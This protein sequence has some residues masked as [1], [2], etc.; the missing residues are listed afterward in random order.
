MFRKKIK[1]STA[2]ANSSL[3]CIPMPYQEQAFS[4]L[5]QQVINL[6]QSIKEKLIQEYA[7]I[8]TKYQQHLEKL[9]CQLYAL[10]LSE[11][12][13]L[14]DMIMFVEGVKDIID[15]GHSLEDWC[16]EAD[17][18]Y[19]AIQNLLGKEK[20]FNNNLLAMLYHTTQVELLFKYDSLLD[21]D[22]Q[23]LS[24]SLSDGNL[25]HHEEERISCRQRLTMLLESGNCTDFNVTSTR[26]QALINGHITALRSL[27][28]EY[29]DIK[30]WLFDLFDLID[31]ENQDFIARS[32]GRSHTFESDIKKFI[33]HCKKIYIDVN[34]E[35]IARNVVISVSEELHRESIKS[36]DD[37]HKIYYFMFKALYLEVE[38]KLDFE[39]RLFLLEKIYEMERD[40]KENLAMVDM[41]ECLKTVL[42]THYVSWSQ[43]AINTSK[44]AL[45]FEEVDEVREVQEKSR[46]WRQF[47]I[48]NIYFQKIFNNSFYSKFMF[49]RESEANDFHDALMEDFEDEMNSFK[50]RLE[51]LSHPTNYKE[52][53]ERTLIS[54]WISH[55]EDFVHKFGNEESFGV[56]GHLAKKLSEDAAYQCLEGE[57]EYYSLIALTKE[58]ITRSEANAATPEVVSAKAASA[59]FPTKSTPLTKSKSLVALQVAKWVTGGVVVGGITFFLL[60]GAWPVFA[61]ASVLVLAVTAAALLVGGGILGGAIALI[62]NQ[63]KVKA[64]L[65]NIAEKAVPF[66]MQPAIKKLFRTNS[67]PDLL[68]SIRLI[69]NPPV[70]PVL[71][72]SKSV[73]DLSGLESAPKVTPEVSTSAFLTKL[74]GLFSISN[75][76]SAKD[77]LVRIESRIVRRP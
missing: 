26:L 23:D 43:S 21:K 50:R 75:Q 12:N 7:P 8:I 54:K 47:A 62:K 63:I 69:T 49:V 25:F 40:H 55:F 52:S 59:V 29:P 9:P 6:Q 64:T 48:D 39:A 22:R 17:K 32:S 10:C 57:R 37:D 19:K 30:E 38:K 5:A 33:S 74:Y 13:T 71:K 44:I 3:A 11:I 20:E 15:K 65:I 56:V 31:R 42:N 1:K 16:G 70:K 76:M 41:E 66:S 67:S 46:R 14:S 61:A 60:A 77:K 4:E 28:K 18:L 72:K 73:A 45:T 35:I 34:R 53:I 68:S 2:E 27:L 24:T 58:L 51:E 36:L